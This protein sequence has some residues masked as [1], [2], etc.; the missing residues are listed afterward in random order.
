VTTGRGPA[1]SLVL[2]RPS[3]RADD[4]LRRLCLAARDQ[5]RRI[6]VLALAPEERPPKGCCDTR[7]VLWNRICR[8]LAGEHLAR[9]AQLVDRHRGVDFGVLVAQVGRADEALAGEALARGADEIVLADPRG[10]GLGRLERRRL[11]RR[12]PLRSARGGAPKTPPSLSESERRG[13]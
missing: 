3:E 10:S 4:T 11:R 9:A 8:E 13:Q 1:H 12:S 5:G 6:T 7:S 2:Y